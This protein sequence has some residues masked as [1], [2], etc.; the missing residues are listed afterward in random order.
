MIRLLIVSLL[1]AAF[2]PQG[3]IAATCA[4]ANPAI[5]SGVVKNVTSNGQTSTYH[6]VGTVTNLGGSAQPKDT[7]QFVDVY[8]D[9]QK[10]DSRGIPPLAPGQSYSFGF[11]WQRAAD[12][13]KGTTTVNFR[14]D[15]HQGSDCNPS[16]G[17]YNVTF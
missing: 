12:A 11:D 3:A 1:A 14:M 4:G 9:K 15:M 5:T 7:L 2:A 16:N 10:H 6:L 17:T 13:G 8:V